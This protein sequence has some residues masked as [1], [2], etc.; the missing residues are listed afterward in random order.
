MGVWNS[1]SSW[2]KLVKIHKSTIFSYLFWVAKVFKNKNIQDLS[3]ITFGMLNGQT[4]W[5]THSILLYFFTF[6]HSSTFRKDGMGV[7]CVA[8]LDEAG[9]VTCSLVEKV[10]FF[11]HYCTSAVSSYSQSRCVI[12]DWTCY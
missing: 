7:L 9:S 5:H 8:I 2:G 11:Q 10:H 6:N 1:L 3:Y 12:Y 4:L